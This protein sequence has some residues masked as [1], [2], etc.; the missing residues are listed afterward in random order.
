V[1]MFIQIEIDHTRMTADCA[2]PVAAICPVDIFKVEDGQLRVLP[3]RVDEC[4]LCELCLEIAPA[5]AIAIC[6]LYSGKTLLSRA[7]AT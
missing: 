7:P 2:D 6:K 1:A 3:Q 4:I 5:N